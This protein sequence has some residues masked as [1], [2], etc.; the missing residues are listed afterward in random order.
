VTEAWRT[1][2]TS[3]KAGR[4]TSIGPAILHGLILACTKSCFEMRVPVAH[5][6]QRISRW[7]TAAEEKSLNSLA[8]S[9]LLCVDPGS[10]RPRGHPRGRSGWF[11]QCWP[12]NRRVSLAVEPD[13]AF[14]PVDF[15]LRSAAAVMP[16]A[17]AIAHLI[18]QARRRVARSSVPTAIRWY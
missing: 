10:R 3:R 18:E 17:G 15:C 2:G 11:D 12:Q 5:A 9:A 7:K 6:V 14:N 4:K 16:S 13:E 8:L 1:S